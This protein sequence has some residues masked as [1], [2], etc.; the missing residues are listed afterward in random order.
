MEMDVPLEGVVAA[1][2]AARR[3][4]QHPSQ[5]EITFMRW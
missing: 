3:A 5:V 1:I 4:G 2:I